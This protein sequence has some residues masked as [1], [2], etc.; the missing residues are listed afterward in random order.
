M[1]A[2]SNSSRSAAGSRSAGARIIG[3]VEKEHDK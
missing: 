2:M 1:R 3:A